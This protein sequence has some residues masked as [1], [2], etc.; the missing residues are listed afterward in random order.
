[1]ADVSGTT[2]THA[3]AVHE[4]DRGREQPDHLRR[5]LVARYRRGASHRHDR[6][7][8]SLDHGGLWNDARNRANAHERVTWGMLPDMANRIWIVSTVPVPPAN[9]SILQFGSDSE[10]ARSSYIEQI[11]ALGAPSDVIA[12]AQAATLTLQTTLQYTD[13]TSGTR[14]ILTTARG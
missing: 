1:V 11:T 2:N 9:P 12:D 10:A 8:S 5:I 4:R 13:P 6:L 14:V 3:R 7:E